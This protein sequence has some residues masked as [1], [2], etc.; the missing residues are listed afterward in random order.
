MGINVN[1]NSMEPYAAVSGAV[2]FISTLLKPPIFACTLFLE[3]Y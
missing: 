3:N 1:I 2:I